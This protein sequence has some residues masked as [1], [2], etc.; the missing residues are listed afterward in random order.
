MYCLLSIH[1]YVSWVIGLWW[2]F[3]FWKNNIF[4]SSICS[5]MGLAISWN[6]FSVLVDVTYIGI[7]LF[8]QFFPIFHQKTKIIK[9]DKVIYTITYLEQ[10]NRKLPIIFA[11]RY[12]SNIRFKFTFRYMRPK[13]RFL[14]DA[15]CNLLLIFLRYFVLKYYKC[16]RRHQYI[17]WVDIWMWNGRFAHLPKAWLLCRTKPQQGQFFFIKSYFC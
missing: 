10:V 6:Q 13:I 17:F 1:D 2:S 11:R 12:N 16:L 14:R 4:I 8:S 15:N 7:Y 3:K 5:L 9:G